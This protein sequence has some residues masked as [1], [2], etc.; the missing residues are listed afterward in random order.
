[1]AAEVSLSRVALVPPRRG[2]GARWLDSPHVMSWMIAATLAF[3]LCFVLY[4]IV[5]NLVMSFQQ[6]TVG[7]LAR[8]ARPMVGL[9]NY[10]RVLGDPAFG[11]V[12][13]NSIFFT[14]VCVLA[15]VFLGFLL[16]LLFAEEFPGAAFFRG[17]ILAGWIMPL[18][19]VGAIFRW[20]YATNGGVI[21]E[22]LIA[23]GIVAQPINW[24]TS[25]ELSLLSIIIANIWYG[26]PFAMILLSAGLANLPKELYEAAHLDGA[27]PLGRLRWVT[28]PLMRP[29][30]LAVLTLCTIYTLRA[31]DLLWSMTGGGPVNSSTTLPL[32]S[33]IFSFKNFDFGAGAAIATLMFGVVILAGLLYVRSIRSEVRL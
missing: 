1:M 7:N 23:A 31:F 33:Y 18:L 27:G 16:A 15:Q 26:A 29:T 6:V 19:V 22:G 30:I 21:N 25:T 9:A 12:L 10:E 20:M 28:L 5:Y 4:P 11:I 14:G 3:L 24:L 8:F 2:L 17:L 13:W 32:W